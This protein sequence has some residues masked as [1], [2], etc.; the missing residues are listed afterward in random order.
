M[1]YKLISEPTDETLSLSS[2]EWEMLRRLAAYPEDASVW[3]PEEG[4]DYTR[5]GISAEEASRM[6]HSVSEALMQIRKHAAEPTEEAQRHPS[7]NFETWT[8]QEMLNHL[9]PS[10]ENPLE[11]FSSPRRLRRGE[12]FVR[13]ASAG[14][15]EVL[16]SLPEEEG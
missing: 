8:R 1:G 6:A 10:E 15:F 5:G 12:N 9:G 14:A 7:G 4:M 11:F 16:P 13:L 2:R 3:G